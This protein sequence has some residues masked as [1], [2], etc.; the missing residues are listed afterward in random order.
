LIWLKIRAL[1]PESQPSARK[2]VRA[3]QAVLEGERARLELDQISNLEL[4]RAQ[5]M[6]ARA[7]N[8]YAGPSPNTTSP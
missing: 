2:A 3:A 8:C 7:R 5:D 6:L 4:L 1:L